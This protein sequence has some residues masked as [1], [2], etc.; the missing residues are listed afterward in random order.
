M[1]WGVLVRGTG[2]VCQWFLKQR[3]KLLKLRGLAMDDQRNA[4]CSAESSI[5][6]KSSMSSVIHVS[7][8]FGSRAPTHF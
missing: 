6:I 1:G 7:L 2:A 5:T 8:L 4:D 3:G